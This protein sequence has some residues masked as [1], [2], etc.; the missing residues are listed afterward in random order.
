MTKKFVELLVVFA[1]VAV[2]FAA[3]SDPNQNQKN[4]E[5]M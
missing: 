5:V 4:L 3:G 1:I 2:V